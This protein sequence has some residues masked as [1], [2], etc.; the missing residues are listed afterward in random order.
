MKSY[1]SP[2]KM[3]MPSLR[4]AVA[5][6]SLQWHRHEPKSVHVGFV[7][8][9]VALGQVCSKFFSFCPVNSIPLWLS[10]LIYHMQDEKWAI[11]CLQF[12]DISHLDINMC[13]CKLWAQLANGIEKKSKIIQSEHTLHFPNNAENKC[14]IFRI[15][16][17]YNLIERLT[18]FRTH[19]RLDTCSMSHSADSGI[20]IQLIPNFVQ[21]QVMN[22]LLFTLIPY[23]HEMTGA[24][25][26]EF[27]RNTPM[28]AHIFYI[29]QTLETK[30]E[31]NGTVH[32]LFI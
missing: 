17:L 3:A 16:H 10:M 1:W 24:H 4:R 11:W 25:Q 27:L 21:C 13:Y 12:R 22:I 20:L 2:S 26:C 30:W 23:A 8:D 19:V 32:Q 31:Y 28:T 9:K 5:S 29:R 6:F 15:S 7:V 18:K 14:G